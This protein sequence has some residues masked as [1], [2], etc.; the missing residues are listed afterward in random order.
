[1][2]EGAKR[3]R[4]IDEREEAL[5]IKQRENMVATALNETIAMLRSVDF[6]KW[7]E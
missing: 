6:R 2:S 3:E 7:F 4:V 5:R 1:M